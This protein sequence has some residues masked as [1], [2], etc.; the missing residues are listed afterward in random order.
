MS[1]AEISRLVRVYREAASD[2]AAAWDGACAGARIDVGLAAAILD[3]REF[4]V[5]REATAAAWADLVRACPGG[6]AEARVRVG[7]T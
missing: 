4:A 2:E 5:L 1:G 6:A 3:G 7:A